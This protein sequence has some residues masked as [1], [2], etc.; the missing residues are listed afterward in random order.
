MGREPEEPRGLPLHLRVPK[1]TNCAQVRGLRVL[2]LV[3]LRLP[4]P[5]I[6]IW[7]KSRHVCPSSKPPPV[8]PFLQPALAGPGGGGFL[9]QSLVPQRKALLDDCTGEFAGAEAFLACVSG[10][11]VWFYRQVTHI[12]NQCQKEAMG[13]EL[14]LGYAPI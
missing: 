3:L 4:A 2:G 8:Q 12:G 10:R 9:F 14:F 1:A 7:G 13:Q 11:V 6:P 5:S